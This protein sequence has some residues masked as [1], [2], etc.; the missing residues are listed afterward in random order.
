MTTG[1]LIKQLDNAI[2]SKVNNCLRRRNMTMT[3]SWVLSILNERRNRT[4][5]L[6]DL[7][8]RLGVAQSTCFGIIRRLQEKELVTCFS[9]DNNKRIKLVSITPAGRKCCN[10]VT[11]E[12]A[13]VESKLLSCLSEEEL[14]SLRANLLKIQDSL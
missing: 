7:E 3:Q 9:P 8:E 4:C 10:A 2:E 14:E 11:K 5:S 6:K 12:A 1:Q 13:A